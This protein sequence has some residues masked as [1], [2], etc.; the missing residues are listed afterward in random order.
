MSDLLKRY[1]HSA[2]DFQPAKLASE[3]P[4]GGGSIL[5]ADFSSFACVPQGNLEIQRADYSRHYTGIYQ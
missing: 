5:G 4:F 2:G 3:Q 1:K